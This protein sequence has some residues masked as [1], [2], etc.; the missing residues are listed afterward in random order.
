MTRVR[1]IS[2]V[3][4]ALLV[5]GVA[6]ESLAQAPLWRKVGGPGG[7][8]VS[9][10]SQTVNGDVLAGTFKGVFRSTDGGQSWG[11]LDGAL[12]NAEV[13]TL[14]A[15]PN[16]DLFAGTTHGLYRS[17]DEGASWHA[18][19]PDTHVGALVVNADGVLFAGAFRDVLRSQDGGDTWHAVNTGLD[20]IRERS[21]KL[22]ITEDGVLFVGAY[23]GGVYRS[24]DDGAQ[25]EAVNTGLTDLSVRVLHISAAGDLLLGTHHGGVFRT[26]DN[27][28]SWQA[29]NGGLPAV[30]VRALLATAEGDLFV[31]AFAGSDEV[32]PGGIYRSTDD[33]QSWQAVDIGEEDVDVRS[34]SGVASGGLFAGSAGGPVYHS[35]DQGESWQAFTMGFNHALVIDLFTATNGD[36]FASVM[37]GG[38]YRTRDEGVSWQTV[39][40][41]P[42]VKMVNYL[43]ESPAG[44]LIALGGSGVFL[45]NDHGDTWR[46]IADNLQTEFGFTEVGFTPAGTILVGDYDGII[47]RTEDEGATWSTTSAQIANTPSQ[48]SSGNVWDFVFNDQ[49]DL[50]TA[51]YGGG[52]FRS[53]D[54]GKTWQAVNNGLTNLKVDKLA[55]NVNGDLYVSADGSIFRSQN[56]GVSWT[57]ISVGLREDAVVTKSYAFSAEGDVYAVCLIGRYHEEQ[58]LFHFD[59]DTQQWIEI[60]TGFD[61]L[62]D[63]TFSASGYLFAGTF[64]DG[65]YRSEEPMASTQQT[66]AV[67]PIGDGV[68]ETFTLAQNYPNPFNPTTAITFDLSKESSLTLTI[69]NALGQRVRTLADGP[70]RAGA[71]RVA[72]DGRDDGGRTV[73]GGVYLYR[74]TADAFTQARTMVLMK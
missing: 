14:V 34:L 30:D 55:R 50:F 69:Y 36:I 23:A 46:S 41:D 62:N 70:Y 66:T 64:G 8:Y 18:V 72:W 26:Q 67:E 6:L 9:T 16:G 42:A 25:W 71:Y 29:L 3:L 40:V 49:G 20:A 2:I 4:V 38:L 28:A 22:A 56:E 12:E 17:S 37:R 39:R 63:V 57:E 21:K 65:I 53:Q 7:A 31:G 61:R 52:A 27:G 59:T 11:A 54:D 13:W 1:G 32:S 45:S 43:A 19:V 74:L 44:N 47:H 73:A 48:Y 10:F 68:P 58:I 35:E 24:S 51:T 60:P 15:H 33:G 5:G